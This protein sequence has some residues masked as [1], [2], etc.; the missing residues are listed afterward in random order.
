MAEGCLRG[1]SLTN[2]DTLL[3]WRGLGPGDW[4]SKALSGVFSTPVEFHV[5]SLPGTG[6]VDLEGQIVEVPD[7]ELVLS[8][9]GVPSCLLRLDVRCGRK[10]V[11]ITS[12]LCIDQGM[13]F[14]GLGW[15]EGPLMGS[16][17]LTQIVGLGT[18]C[19]SM[20]DRPSL[21]VASPPNLDRVFR[22]FSQENALLAYLRRRD[23]AVNTW[24]HLGSFFPVLGRSS[25]VLLSSLPRQTAVHLINPPQASLHNRFLTDVVD[26]CFDDANCAE[27][28][29]LDLSA[30]PR[31]VISLCMRS[32]TAVVIV[33]EQIPHFQ[34]S[35]DDTAPIEQAAIASPV[36]ETPPKANAFI[37]AE[38]DLATHLAYGEVEYGSVTG[39]TTQP[40][41]AAKR[42]CR[43]LRCFVAEG[44]GKGTE[45]WL[46]Q[47]Q[48][49]V[50]RRGRRR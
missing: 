21:L 27:R 22:D 42:L 16:K 14:R 18:V 23:D 38:D 3:K 33:P 35:I 39:R 26:L 29:L 5:P 37:A 31:T 28:H 6:V 45:T 36:P 34:S 43:I 41:R 46:R 44:A 12:G 50:R 19:P 13:G 4:L 47:G 1:S 20:K 9:G 8:G 48:K 2:V 40:G 32:V 10:M 17:T 24:P 11:G 49:R 30:P 25:F 7:R 15:N